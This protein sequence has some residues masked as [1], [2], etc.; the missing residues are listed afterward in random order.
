LEVR[1]YRIKPG[2]SSVEALDAPHI[3]GLRQADRLETLATLSGSRLAAE[4][5]KKGVRKEGP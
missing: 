3:E 2:D 5:R 1:F 4:A